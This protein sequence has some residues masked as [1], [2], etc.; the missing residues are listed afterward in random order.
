MRCINGH[1]G[2]S[3]DRGCIRPVFGHLSDIDP[4]DIISRSQSQPSIEQAVGNGAGGIHQ[5][6]VADR[7]AVSLYPLRQIRLLD[8]IGMPVIDHGIAIPIP[9]AYDRIIGQRIGVELRLEN[10]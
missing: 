5:A 8:R 9:V 6:D 3:E 7:N 10:V 4:H 2:H 1:F